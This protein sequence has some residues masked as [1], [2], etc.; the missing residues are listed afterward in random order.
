MSRLL[1]MRHAKASFGD[2]LEDFERPLADVGRHEAAR[3][4]DWIREHVGTVDA[5][6]CSSAVRTRET[7]DA[8]GLQ[9]PT[10]FLDEIY[11][12]WTG[13]LLDA[14][15]SVDDAAST[16]LLIGH[17]PG[18][19]GLAARLANDASDPAVVDRVR[20]GFPTAAIAVLEVD[21]PWSDLDVG[22]ARLTDV[23]TTH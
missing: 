21:G 23:V 13:S 4:G 2:G 8:T 18:T 9:A 3:A 17:A 5:V 6:L 20:A 19:P 12:G 22:T 10:R 1:L 16:V 15:R 7:L 11:E 14:V